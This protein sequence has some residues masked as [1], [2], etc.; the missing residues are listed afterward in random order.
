MIGMML[1]LQRIVGRFVEKVEDV[2][3][4]L[5]FDGFVEVDVVFESGVR[6]TGAGSSLVPEAV[7]IIEVSVE[8]LRLLLSQLTLNRLRMMPFD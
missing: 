5:G 6:N 2:R 4:S 3:V 1:L 8:K 7:G